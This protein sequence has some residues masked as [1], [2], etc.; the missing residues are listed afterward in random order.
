MLQWNHGTLQPSSN[1]F[2]HDAGSS[3]LCPPSFRYSLP[4]SELEAGL[5]PTPVP[6][7]SVLESDPM[8]P[9]SVTPQASLVTSRTTVTTEFTVQGLDIVIAVHFTAQGMWVRV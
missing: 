3:P 1:R 5:Q 8:R 4:A 6:S 7:T 2:R 9:G